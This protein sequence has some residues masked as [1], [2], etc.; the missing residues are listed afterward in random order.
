MLH[1][2]VVAAIVD[3]A[4]CRPVRLDRRAGV[5]AAVDADEQPPG[6][7]PRADA[8]ADSRR[9]RRHRRRRR[10]AD[11]VPG[12]G[13]CRFGQGPTRHLAPPRGRQRPRGGEVGSRG[14]L[15]RDT[16]QPP[17]GGRPPRGDARHPPR[18]DAPLGAHGPPR[19]RPPAHNG[20]HGAA[21]ARR[22]G[23]LRRAGGGRRRPAERAGRAPEAAG[24]LAPPAGPVARPPGGNNRRPP[25]AVVVDPPLRG[26]DG[27]EGGAAD[28]ANAAAGAG[29]RP[30]ADRCGAADLPHPPGRCRR[31]A[32]AV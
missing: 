18:V 15:R 30:K 24:R 2:K 3:V 1:G 5:G 4:A 12:A 32:E 23:R 27:R 11:R 31:R 10:V 20:G 14:A 29:A 8:A 28:A 13:G 9:R 22:A 19:A 17:A 21:H 25:V 7:C 6:W 16:P 26:G